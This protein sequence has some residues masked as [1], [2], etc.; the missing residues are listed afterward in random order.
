MPSPDRRS[1]PSG[2]TNAVG[3]ENQHLP[4]DWRE[5]G[6]ADHYR[7]A[8]ALERRSGR[9]ATKA[10]LATLEACMMVR[11]LITTGRPLELLAGLT[12]RA[13]QRGSAVAGLPPG[14]IYRERQWSWWLPSGKPAVTRVPDKTSMVPIS[15]NIWLPVSTGMAPLLK[16]CLEA[17]RIQPSAEL[18]P[19]FV[20]PEA[21]IQRRVLAILQSRPLGA[22][23]ARRSATTVESTHR[24][25]PR[26][27]AQG[28]GGDPAAASLITGRNQTLARPMTHY[29]ALQLPEAINIHADAT[30][31]VDRHH[32]SEYPA[33]LA[34]LSIGDPQTPTDKAVRDMAQQLAA[35]LV[36]RGLGEATTHG[37]MMRHTC[38]L[39]SFALALRGSGQLPAFKSVDQRTGFCQVHDKY[40]DDP[41]QARLMW[42]PK[43]ARDQLL[44]YE[45]HLG[46][47]EQWLGTAAR[48]QLAA[49]RDDPESGA[50]LF[51]VRD[52][53]RLEFV[54]LKKVLLSATSFGW[55]GRENA[56]RH[57]LRS[58]LSGRCSAETLG[59]YFG[60]WQQGV[61]PWGA[62]S[63]LDPLSYRADLERC[64]DTL[65]R[66]AGW[67]AMP[68]PLR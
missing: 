34:A 53:Y 22:Q 56:G 1:R 12:F 5:L 36:R 15:P 48:A 51:W 19:L 59:A 62:T 7:I 16:R 26:V 44:M 63:S 37:A 68:T 39:V 66:D 50:P 54:D 20:T 58:K 18:L 61:D 11:A 46:R 6:A 29:G 60:H 28:A 35:C 64:L 43:V 13:V 25:L 65:L 31:A 30:R 52:R 42:V 33:E 3:R 57:W 21:T 9:Q 32:H 8:D 24:W 67:R 40:R 47:L 17:R 27:I 41:R 55:R 14:L 23:K 4:G 49:L 2:Y 10:T 45:E 38:A